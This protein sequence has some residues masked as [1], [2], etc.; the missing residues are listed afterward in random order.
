MWGHSSSPS[1]VVPGS[2][3]WLTCVCHKC[4]LQH[5]STVRVSSHTTQGSAKRAAV[6][7]SNQAE[8]AASPSKGWQANVAGSMADADAGCGSTGRHSPRASAP[9]VAKRK[10]LIGSTSMLWTPTLAEPLAVTSCRWSAAVVA[11]RCQKQQKEVASQQ[12]GNLCPISM[13]ACIQVTAGSPH[14]A[15]DTAGSWGRQAVDAHQ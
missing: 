8:A 12:H 1:A 13:Q 15:L 7:P 6:S 3:G 9:P 2:P 11:V 10:G 14:E 5:S 4:V